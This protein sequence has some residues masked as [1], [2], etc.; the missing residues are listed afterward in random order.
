MIKYT[1]FIDNMSAMKLIKN[2]EFH[3]RSKHIDV[4]YYF[5]RDNY[6]K[7]EIDVMYVQSEL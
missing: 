2:P 7:G 4:K 6:Q 5:V 1:L 3:Q